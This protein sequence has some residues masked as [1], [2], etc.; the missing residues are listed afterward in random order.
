MS[1]DLK[2]HVQSLAEQ[3]ESFHQA[4]ETKAREIEIN[5]GDQ[6]IVGKLLK[7]SDAMKDSANIYLSW[8]RHY[9]NLS[10]GGASEADEGEEDSEDFQF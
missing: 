6:E 2:Q 5:G 4:L 1:S 10:E 8:A 3:M 9:V 7:G